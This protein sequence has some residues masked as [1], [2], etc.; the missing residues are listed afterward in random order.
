[1]PVRQRQK[2]QELPHA[3]GGG[4]RNQ[5]GA[6]VSPVTEQLFHSAMALSEEERWELVE[7]LLAECDPAQVRPFDDAWLAEVQRRSAEIDAGTAE[8]TP[9]ADVKR[10]V[11]QRLEG[12]AALSD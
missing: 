7:A 6:T 12:K 10:R 11:R 2:I 9:W 5:E 1:M 8:L 4:V 3:L